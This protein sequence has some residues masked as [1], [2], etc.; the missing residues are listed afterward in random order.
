MWLLIPLLT[1]TSALSYVIDVGREVPKVRLD[2]CSSLSD[3]AHS[4]ICDETGTPLNARPFTNMIGRHPTLLRIQPSNSSPFV[5]VNGRCPSLRIQ[6]FTLLSGQPS[7][8]RIQP[9][10]SG[11]FALVNGRRPSSPRFQLF[12]LLSGQPSMSTVP[13]NS[14]SLSPL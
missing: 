1:F 7:T 8:S 10:N 14:P 13:R 5:L 3:R 12:A 11:P 9:S 4:P 2:D 6:L